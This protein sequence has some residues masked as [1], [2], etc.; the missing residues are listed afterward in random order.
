MISVRPAHCPY[1]A[2]TLTFQFFSDTI[3]IINVKHDGSAYWA[4]PI[5]NTFC[6]RDCISRSQQCQTLLAELF[7]SNWVETLYKCWLPQADHEYTTDF[8]FCTCLTQIIDIF[9]HLQKNFEIKFFS[10][11][12][13][14]RSFKL[15]MIMTLLGVNILIVALMILTL[16]QG[17]RCARNI[18]CKFGFLGFCLDFC[19]LWFK[20]C[21][22]ATYI[23]VHGSLNGV[24]FY[25][26][27]IDLE[28]Q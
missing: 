16:F 9:P 8:D 25:L 4:S 19:L 3:S 23:L 7:L 18:N 12:V 28:A 13:I 6:E 22:I 1:V 5:H 24:W 10:D 26:H 2:K 11:T 20:C 21:M 15:F 17:H 27:K 14:A